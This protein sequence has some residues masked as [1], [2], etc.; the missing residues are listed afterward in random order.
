MTAI[1]STLTH[2]YR[3]YNEV[4]SC[5]CSKPAMEGMA[6]MAS[7]ILQAIFRDGD[8][9]LWGAFLSRNVSFKQKREYTET[10]QQS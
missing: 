1:G 5:E 6:A 3:I 2:Y 9:I 4:L 7:A 10:G 8:G